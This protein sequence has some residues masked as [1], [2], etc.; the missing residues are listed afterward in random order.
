MAWQQITAP[1]PEGEQRAAV[2]GTGTWGTMLAVLL[3]RKG[4]EVRL[5][6]RTGE[7]AQQLETQRE[8]PCR[9][10][11]VRFPDTLHVTASLAE[12]LDRCRLVLV[13]VPAQRMRQNAERI[14]PYL[15]PES[16]VVSATKGLERGTALRM[17]EVLAQVLPPE[18]HTRLAVLSGPNLAREIA[19]GLPAVSV[20]ASTDATVARRVQATLFCPQ[21]RVYTNPDPV[22]VELG[23]A[24][25]NIIAIGAGISDGLGYGD[26]AK[27]AFIT[28]GLAEMARLGVACG[29]HPLTFAGLAGL[30]DLI[31][32]CNS[33]LSRNHYVGL[34]LAKGR[35]WPE[36]QA[37]MNQVAEGVET[38]AAARI[39]AERYRVE[40]PITE[41]MYQ[42]LFEGKHP[43]QAVEE[44]LARPPAEEWR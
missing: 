13:A 10:P 1:A 32:T 20:V 25:K 19:A 34:E 11:G 17:T 15:A 40:M 8:N 21:L 5:W 23:G 42:V 43:R 27:A 41:Q 9:L 38:T 14:A 24:L 22:G 16:I 39:L 29:A 2:I 7:E 3:A 18:R 28:R 33:P 30:G 12:A 44:L 31:A 37:G 6:A 35:S 36:I 4:L 26:N